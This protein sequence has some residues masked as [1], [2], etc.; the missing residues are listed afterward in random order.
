MVRY[1]LH[2]A[3]HLPSW[4]ALYPFASHFL[5]LGGQRLHYLDEGAGRPL[6]M[7]HGNPTWSFYWRRLIEH[8]RTG[9]RVVAVDHIGCGLSDKPQDPAHY[10][11][12]HHIVNL[13]ALLDRL[14]LRE[15]TLV[16]HDW[17]GPIGLGAALARPARFRAFVLLNT[18]AFPP[19]FIPW[20]IRLS[21]IPV[22]GTWC[23][24]RL[25]LFARG[26]LRMAVAKRD[27]MTRDVRAGLLAPYDS[28][29]HRVG[30]DRFVQDIPSSPNHPTWGVLQELERELSGLDRPCQLIWGMRD[31]CFRPECLERLRR[32]FPHAEVHRLEDAAHYVVEDAPEQV[33]AKLEQFLERLG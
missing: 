32:I 22:L 12:S 13:V 6:L 2:M 18:G 17:G 27:R 30:I 33:I 16:A 20:R 15:T 8:F 3:E 1:T 31:W 28:W 9:H 23:I 29:A 7:V 4:R 5:W 21:R 19:P 10:S 25:N 24:R 14:D 11:L 26:A